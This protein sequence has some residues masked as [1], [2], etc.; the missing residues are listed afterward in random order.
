[1]CPYMIIKAINEKEAMHLKK[2]LLYYNLIN[3]RKQNSSWMIFLHNILK[4]YGMADTATVSF[5][6]LYTV[7]INYNTNENK[8]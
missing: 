2:M 7:H 6:A 1:M 3:K 4:I 5:T 8:F